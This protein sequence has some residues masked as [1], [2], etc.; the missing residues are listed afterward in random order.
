[1][2]RC[3]ASEGEI[4]ILKIF[5]ERAISRSLLIPIDFLNPW[6]EILRQQSEGLIDRATHRARKT[7]I[8][9]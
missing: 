1:M 2:N 6:L 3:Q 7:R 4:K 9:S 8:K 5:W